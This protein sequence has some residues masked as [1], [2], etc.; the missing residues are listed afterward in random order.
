VGDGRETTTAEL[1]GDRQRI[2]DWRTVRRKGE[3]D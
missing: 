3:A 1:C 2:I